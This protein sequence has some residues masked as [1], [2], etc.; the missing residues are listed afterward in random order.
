MRIILVNTTLETSRFPKI[1]FFLPPYWAAI[2]ARKIREH[3]D[4][5]KLLDLQF[6]NP[7]NLKI[8]EEY[9]DNV[10]A[11]LVSGMT[12]CYPQMMEVSKF[13]RNKGIKVI[14]GG[15]AATAL[16]HS[17]DI[18]KLEE[19]LFPFCDAAVIGEAEAAIDDLL[20][21]LK[22]KKLRR[23]RLYIGNPDKWDWVMPDFTI[24][25]KKYAFG[26]IQTQRGCPMNCKFCSVANALGKRVRAKPVEF[27]RKEIELLLKTHR[28]DFIGFYDDNIIGK[29]DGKYAHEL[30]TMFKNS[31]PKV[32]WFSQ[33]TTRIIDKPGL[34]DIFDKS[35]CAALL[36]GFESLSQDSLGEVTHKNFNHSTDDE[37]EEKYRKVVT[38]LKEHGIGTWGCF[39]YGFEHDKKD[40]FEKSLKFALESGILFYQATILT[41]MPGTP[42]FRDS[43]NKL[44]Y[45][46]T[47][48]NWGKY[49]F[50][51]PTMTRHTKY[52]DNET[53]TAGYANT[54]R[55]F[56]GRT[57][58]LYRILKSRMPKC[59]IAGCVKA[60]TKHMLG[61]LANNAGA[62]FFHK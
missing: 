42:F 58:V 57:N 2:L 28:F 51:R 53:L 22:R 50:M 41:P 23:D 18:I 36:V 4:E 37:R 45:P 15:W 12:P 54:N 10:D 29:D 33:C 38:M 27:V 43:A 56:Y 40:V 52:M 14:F 61:T 11:V 62:K 59:F 24:W 49:D 55:T 9:Y 60:M 16:Y 25:D 35:G 39:I 21:D 48:E 46:L 20:E 1:G 8:T 19:H 6:Q 30:F 44:L 17:K 47:P 5:A 3:G 32:R 13:Y 31:F 7:N 26:A 34:L